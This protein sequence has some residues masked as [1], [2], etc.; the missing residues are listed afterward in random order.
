LGFP[1]VENFGIEKWLRDFRLY[2]QINKFAMKKQIQFQ[3]RNW[4]FKPILDILNSLDR[5][6][7]DRTLN[8]KVE[9]PNDLNRKVA[10]LSNQIGL[11]NQ[12]FEG[13]EAE[14]SKI[15]SGYLKVD[16][17]T[18]YAAILFDFSVY[19]KN[20]PAKV[21]KMIRK[22]SLEG[23]DSGE[24]PILEK[25]LLKYFRSTNS[26]EIGRWEQICKEIEDNSIISDKNLMERL[27]GTV[28]DDKRK[29]AFIERAFFGFLRDY[30]SN[31]LILCEEL[32][33]FGNFMAQTNNFTTDV[34]SEFSVDAQ[35]ILQKSRNL[36]DLKINYVPLF[37]KKS[38]L[39]IE[40][41]DFIRP[42]DEKLDSVYSNI[43]TLT[44]DEVIEIKSFGFERLKGYETNETKV[45]LYKVKR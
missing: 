17:L 45:I 22:R 12:K 32:R 40:E 25:L 5:K 24:I 9:F 6:V 13:K 31:T 1:N 7:D 34:E 42:S 2:L 4:V 35:E 44:G 19:L 18:G 16:I 38:E 28:G 3:F 37:K 29:Q 41:L 14:N 39:T 11:L 43:T 10:E 30:I 21:Q 23:E 20:I 8:Q 36:L 15:S 26:F 33:N 27:S